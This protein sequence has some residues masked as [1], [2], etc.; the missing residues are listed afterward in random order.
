MCIPTADIHEHQLNFWIVPQH[1][2]G[3]SGGVVS[4]PTD[5]T[6]R[7][8]TEP[9]LKTAQLAAFNN[10]GKPTQLYMAGAIKQEFSGFSGIAVNRIDNNPTTGWAV[11]GATGKATE[12]LFETQKPIA[13]AKGARLTVTMLQ[14]FGTNHNIGKFRIMVT[15]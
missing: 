8:F 14:R 5:G 13:F 15:T 11:F 7:A 9:L 10:G 6:T 12:A 2:G 1:G 4:A 3:F